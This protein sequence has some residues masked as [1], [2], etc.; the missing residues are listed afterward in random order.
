[1]K[2]KVTLILAVCAMCLLA[3][4]GGKEKKAQGAGTL[5]ISDVFTITSRGTVVTG[6]VESGVICVGD[7]AVIVKEDGTELETEVMLIEMFRQT[8]D[9]AKEGDSVGIQ[10]DGLEKNQISVGDKLVVGG[11]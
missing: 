6:T 10:V 5:E 1:M 11:E 4:C 3:A 7:K 8:M 9:E 2:R